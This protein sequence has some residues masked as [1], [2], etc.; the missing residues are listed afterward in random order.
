MKTNDKASDNEWK[1]MRASK[2]G[3]FRYQ[4]NNY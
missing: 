2:T 1:Q 3:W 4:N